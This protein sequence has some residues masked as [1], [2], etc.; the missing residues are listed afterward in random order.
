MRGPVYASSWL[1]CQQWNLWEL[2]Y[3]NEADEII[4]KNK[5]ELIVQKKSKTNNY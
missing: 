4:S 2:T 1:C 5:D 3:K